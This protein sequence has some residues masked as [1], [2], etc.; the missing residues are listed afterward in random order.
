MT[1]E[2]EQLLAQIALLKRD[3]TADAKVS[4]LLARLDALDAV[5]TNVAPDSLTA[6]QI[7]LLVARRE[8]RMMTDDDYGMGLAGA[9]EGS[10]ISNDGVAGAVL[11]DVLVIVAPDGTI[12]VLGPG[13][14]DEDEWWQVDLKGGEVVRVL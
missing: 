5:P 12:S 7:V 10:W 1:T 4:V 14:T 11:R 3:S 2:R 9:P 6:G 8:F 13:A